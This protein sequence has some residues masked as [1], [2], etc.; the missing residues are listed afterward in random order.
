MVLSEPMLPSCDYQH[1]KAA[2]QVRLGRAM[3]AAEKHILGE[4]LRWKEQQAQQLMAQQAQQARPQQQQQQQQQQVQ[5]V[6]A[7]LPAAPELHFCPQQSLDD[8]PIEGM[9][10][11]RKGHMDMGIDIDAELDLL[12]D[13]CAGTTGT[14]GGTMSASMSSMDVVGIDS[15]ITSAA[16]FR[17]SSRSSRSTTTTTTTSGGGSSSSA[18]GV[19]SREQPKQE[20]QEQQRP[21][22]NRRAWF[23]RSSANN[24][25][26]NS[27][28]SGLVAAVVRQRGWAHVAMALAKAHQ[29][30]ERKMLAHA[31]KAVR[32]AERVDADVPLALYA[33]LASH[34]AHLVVA[35]KHGHV[36]THPQLLRTDTDA[37]STDGVA[38]GAATTTT[39]N[40]NND[41]H[42]N[43][44][45]GVG[46]EAE[47]ARSVA[48]AIAH[49]EKAV[50][51]AGERGCGGGALATGTAE[52]DQRRGQTYVW[53]G[54][55]S[56]THSASFAQ[57]GGAAANRR[58]A[59]LARR[60][61]ELH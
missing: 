30:R 55:L 5:H 9:V 25:N 32:D 17:S 39:N 40:N 61:L 45:G 21:T 51:L 18:P 19:R 50:A 31:H 22:K 35:C 43:N 24:N 47:H 13:L 33:H 60:A 56:R 23:G 59:A 41:N 6:P 48:L 29:G 7:P 20:Q 53:D 16:S 54:A 1:A 3:T 28:N 34:T 37:T 4:E 57:R 42:I 15:L 26:T 2:I 27:T 8:S 58:A 11:G 14:D 10:A 38:D 46:A 44:V 36:L 52:A 12:D 49:A